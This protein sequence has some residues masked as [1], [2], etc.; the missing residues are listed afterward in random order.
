MA[1][2]RWSRAIRGAW[3]GSCRTSSATLS[4][5]AETA[6]RSESAATSSRSRIMGRALHPSICRTCSSAS[7]RRIRRAPAAAPGSG[8]PSRRRTRGSSAAGSKSRV[9]RGA[10]AASRFA[11]DAVTEPL[12]G[13]HGPVAGGVEDGAMSTGTACCGATRHSP[14]SALAGWRPL[15]ALDVASGRRDDLPLCRFSV[16]RLLVPL[17]LFVVVTSAAAT[18]TLDGTNLRVA[19]SGTGA[20]ADGESWAAGISADGHFVAFTSVA[21]NLV[22]RDLNS[23]PDAFVRDL[24][25]GRTERV[26]VAADGTE[27]NLESAVSSISANGRYVVFNS[28]ASNLAEHDVNGRRDAFVR[29]LRTDRTTLVSVSSRGRQGNGDSDSGA[30]SANG[31]YVAFVSEAATLVPRDTNRAPDVFVRDLKTHNTFRVNVGPLN[32]PAVRGSET[33]SPSISAGGRYVAFASDA[34]NL[35]RHDTN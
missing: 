30:I 17:L 3:S 11:S 10:A 21:D 34:P 32:R 20:P 27:G 16:K 2:K 4:S 25:G 9:S 6:S 18:A 23:Q 14:T 24:R 33:G 7:T 22:E 1:A 31:R 13:R 12:R 29:D 28:D 15:P 26:S 5:T 8:S 19:V 35:V